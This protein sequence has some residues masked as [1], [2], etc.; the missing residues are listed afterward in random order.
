MT[1][2]FFFV[3]QG[4][5]EFTCTEKATRMAA[6]EKKKNLFRLLSPVD[7]V[8]GSLEQIDHKAAAA[9]EHPQEDKE[10]GLY[11]FSCKFFALSD[12]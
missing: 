9:S 7:F 11:Q 4:T 2:R 10:S 8:Y 5:F 1:L 12:N 3:L 6:S